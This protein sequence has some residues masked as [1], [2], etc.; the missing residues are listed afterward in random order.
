MKACS[1]S[2]IIREMQIKITMR[3]HFTPP[4]IA[5]IKKSAV[6]KCWRGYG[7]KGNLLHWWW[8]CKLVKPLW[9]TLWS[10]LKKSKSRATI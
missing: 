6:N 8:E 3:Y 9:I 2:L 4:G 5:I 1:T 7:V 10:F